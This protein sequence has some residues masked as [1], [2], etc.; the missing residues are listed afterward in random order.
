MEVS[1]IQ[2]KFRDDFSST[3]QNAIWKV[4]NLGSGMTI[5]WATPSGLRILAGNTPSQE[6]ILR[7]T[8]GWETPVRAM[9]LAL[10]ASLINQR[11]ANQEI[12]L[13]LVSTDG[14][15]YVSW[16]FDGTVATTSKMHSANHGVTA[17]D[18]SVTT[19]LDT[20][21][22]NGC[23]ELEMWPD[24]AY[25]HQR[26][27]DSASARVVSQ[28]RNRR[29]PDPTE[30]LHIEIRVRNLASAPTTGTIL[31]LDAILVQDI[32]ELTVEV[33]GGR[34][35]GAASQSVPVVQVGTTTITGTVTANLG[36]GGTS[37]TSLGKAE[38]A[39]HASG[40]T[41]VAI[42]GVRAPAAPVA[43]TSAAGDYGYVMVDAE[44][45]V[46][47]ANTADPTLNEQVVVDATLTTDVALFA[48]AGAGIRHYVTDLTFENT[49]A[50]SVRV[51]VDDGGT[52]IYS[53]TVAAG[54]T[55]SKAFNT[56]LKGTAATA[57][58][59]KLSA[60]GTVTVSAQGY[61]GI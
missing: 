8:R 13:A 36:T 16:L 48:A 1:T 60:A 47:V 26:T 49:G 52:R 11:V 17:T 61:K 22:G 53:A 34:G 6:T 2:E 15:S 56:P 54:S 58:N 38:D 19:G 39:A 3:D 32:S 33:V 21:T 20:N 55:F 57:L 4:V 40:D 28:V 23:F 41:G 45:K 9:F 7:T 31:A 27:A 42:F 30:K 29:I 46:V 10:G 5:D 24:E 25:W 44:G 12:E 35:A 14:T 50:A 37:A 18:T 51:I 59:V 43:G